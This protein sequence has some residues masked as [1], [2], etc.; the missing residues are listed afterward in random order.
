MNLSLLQK[1]AT[2]SAS[3]GGGSNSSSATKTSPIKRKTTSDD[4]DEILVIN[5][6]SNNKKIIVSSNNNSANSN[7]NIK[8]RDSAK[9]Q[10]NKNNRAKDFVDDG[11]WIVVSKNDKKQRQINQNLILNEMAA[12]LFQKSSANNGDSKVNVTAIVSP[13]S[14]AKGNSNKKVNLKTKEL[15]EK[16]NQKQKELEKFSDSNNSDDAPII[17]APAAAVNNNNLNDKL[18]SNASTPVVVD[19]K[20]LD[21][22]ISGVTETPDILEDKVEPNVVTKKNQ[23][24]TT[25]ASAKEKALNSKNDAKTAIKNKEA[26]EKQLNSSEEP[27][28][29]GVDDIGGKSIIKGSFS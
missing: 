3:S 6:N 15:K 13:Q 4:D 11:S 9:Q 21:N 25:T 19:N 29:I 20:I 22:V 16:A 26:S 2:S 28:S 14:P 23:L 1:V 18:N 24:I 8:K 17:A 10:Q 12:N 5:N 7:N 27:A